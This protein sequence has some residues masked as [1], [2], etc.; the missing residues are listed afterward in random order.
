MDGLER[1]EPHGNLGGIQTGQHRGDINH[2]DGTQQNCDWPME[3]YRPTER[4]F[5]DD[6][7][8]DQR[9]RESESEAR[10]IREQTKQASFNENLL[11]HLSGRRAEKT[12]QPEFAP[13]VDH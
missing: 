7:D 2:A 6:V 8:K 1:V 13:A 9:E 11:A 4:L 10:K 5:V 12:Q 3:L